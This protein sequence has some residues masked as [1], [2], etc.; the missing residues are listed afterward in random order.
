MIKIADM[1]AMLTLQ[2]NKFSS[3]TTKNQIEIHA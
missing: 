3:S 1:E 2:K